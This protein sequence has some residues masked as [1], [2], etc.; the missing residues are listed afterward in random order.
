MSFLCFKTSG[1]PDYLKHKTTFCS[2]AFTNSQRLSS[3]AGCPKLL[4]SSSPQALQISLLAGMHLC[5]H[6][7]FVPAFSPF[8]CFPCPSPK[9]ILGHSESHSSTKTQLSCSSFCFF[10]SSVTLF[11]LTSGAFNEQSIH[12]TFCHLQHSCLTS[13]PFK[14]PNVYNLSL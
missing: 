9:T 2:W 11:V 14:F 5:V 12:L 6:A 13:Y 4:Y 10:L 7:D 1:W 8:S 3:A